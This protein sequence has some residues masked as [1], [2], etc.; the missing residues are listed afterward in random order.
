VTADPSDPP[1][2]VVVVT[3]D[4]GDWFEETLASLAAQD[5]ANLSILIV[6]AGS[7]RDPTARVA[8][9][10]PGAVVHRV[11][12]P[13]P[14]GCAANEVLG[15]VAGA[16]HYLLCHDDVALAP[17]V[18]RLLV[19]EALRR[20]AGVASPKLVAWQDPR[21]LLA[22]GLGADRVGV[23]HG[24]IER[25]EL[26]QNQHDTVRDIFVAPGGATLVRADLFRSLGGFDAGVP[27]RGE[28]L[29][30]CWRAHLAGARIVVVPAARVRHLEAESTGPE[31][32]GGA[33]RAGTRT[34][35]HRMRTVLSCYSG[36][37]L[38]WVLPLLV[39]Q[40]GAG[41]FADLGAGRPRRAAGRVAALAEAVGDPGTL[42]AV[43]RRIQRQRRRSDRQVRR[44]QSRGSA[45][46]RA[47]TRARLH[48]LERGAVAAAPGPRGDG[49]ISGD[50]A[51]TGWRPPLLVAGL[52]IV[53]LTIGSRGLLGHDL[54]A[55][56]QLPDTSSGIG[57]W[58]RGWW[59][60]WQPAG[61]GRA[62]P[63]PPALVLLVVVGTLGLGAFGTLQHLLVLGPLLLGPFGAY[64]AAR[65]WG[66]PRGRL[67]AAVV[68]AVI[69]LPYN[70][71]AGGEWSGLLTYAA[72]PWLIDRLARLSEGR[73]LFSEGRTLF[74]EGRTRPGAGLLGLGLLTG[75]VGAFVPAFVLVV[76]VVGIALAL[77][78]VLVASIRPA[79]RIAVG[80][81]A[82]GAIGLGLL[83]PWSLGVVTT[84]AAMFGAPAGPAG[85]L[86]F[87]SLLRLHT[88]PFGSGPLDWGLLAAA[89]LPLLTGRSWRLAWA[90]RLWV[91]MLV[92]VGWAWLG[93][94]GRVPVPPVE[95]VLA[96][97]GAALA[98][99]VGLGVSAFELDL[100]D[101]RFGWRQGA[102]ALAA[103]GVVLSVLPFVGGITGGRWK[104]PGAGSAQVLAGEESPDPSGAVSRLLWIGAPRALPLASTPLPGGQAWATSSEGPPGLV[105]E[106]AGGRPRGAKVF[107]RDIVLAENGLTTNLGHL[108][109]PLG[110][111]Y[112]V[113]PN[114][115]APSG[116]DAVATPTSGRIESGLSLQTDLDQIALDPNYT[117]YENAAWAPDLRPHRP[118][119][120]VDRT[121]Q[122][123]LVLVWGELIV[124]ALDRRRRPGPS[125]AGAG[126]QSQALA[127]DGRPPSAPAAGAA[128]G[129]RRRGS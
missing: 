48:R 76:P 39:A 44:L 86:S 56:G 95:V 49:R 28:D 98:L 117:V 82:G 1:V 64:R 8:A 2:V 57:S 46:F 112:V 114:H 62:G 125:R 120:L 60:T 69:P 111:R 94:R 50:G 124:A 15:V 67:A 84:P 113:L 19:D 9:R 18:T 27:D 108:L 115:N 16:S 47:W 70:A 74:S 13:L 45:R 21:R 41:A 65:R 4:P 89:A 87:A 53:L 63:S 36:R 14:W 79:V 20:N 17:D 85:R 61:L 55:I 10:L 96:P 43:R 31:E 52:L 23:V 35:R 104:L 116:T 58:W 25:G 7:T 102:S 129:A 128:E 99:L 66:S 3:R 54:P 42:L 51:A 101:Y 40:T 110:V 75:L 37:N 92:S 126:R 77:G 80:A 107:Q 127:R 24:L 109:A 91:V 121:G 26:D 73:T 90:G 11:A 119:S 123:L 78:T 72:A 122:V 59:D 71:L 88:G 97:A 103:A 93:L 100:P 6:D 81:L 38:L 5:H 118:T 68:Y 12:V 32:P 22:V 29:D 106:W 34:D 105:D 33:E 83:L 30:L